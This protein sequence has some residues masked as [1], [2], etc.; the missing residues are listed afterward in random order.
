MEHGTWS[1]RHVT[2]PTRAHTAH[3]ARLYSRNLARRAVLPTAP[4]ASPPL[5]LIMQHAHAARPRPHS[6]MRP[7]L[8]PL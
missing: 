4:W 6:V 2:L 3:W 7:S 8:P 5:A 1:W